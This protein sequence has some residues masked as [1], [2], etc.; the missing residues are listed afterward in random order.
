MP[1]KVEADRDQCIGA[2]QCLI[3]TS[4]FALDDDGKVVVL[5]DGIPDENELEVAR[6]AV[7]LCPA[8]ALT[9]VEDD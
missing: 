8:E 7:A 3:A 9:L 4:V 2:G 5:N 6:D 1:I